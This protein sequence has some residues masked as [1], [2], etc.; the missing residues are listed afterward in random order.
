ML[1]GLMRTPGHAGL[2]RRHRQTVVE[3]DVGD[4]RHR[5]S[6]HQRRQGFGGGL[7]GDRHPHERGPGRRERPDLAEGGLDVVGAGVG[8]R[9]DDDRSATP[10]RTPP[11]SPASRLA[12]PPRV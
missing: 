1:P 2:Y 4:Q 10:H 8:H 7:V 6:G 12:I 11:T 3:V 5:R 9:L